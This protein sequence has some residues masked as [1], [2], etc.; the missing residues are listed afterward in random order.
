MISTYKSAL[1]DLFPWFFGDDRSHMQWT[2][3]PNLW[4]YLVPLSSRR[5]TDDTVSYLHAR[6]LETKDKGR[7]T[8]G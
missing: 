2:D 7:Q 5:K 6:H 4:L 1:F 8:L 3:D